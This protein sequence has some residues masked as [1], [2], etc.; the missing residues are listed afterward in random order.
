MQQLLVRHKSVPHK[1]MFAQPIPMIGH[2]DG[3]GIFGVGPVFQQRQQLT[4]VGI[5]VRHFGVVQVAKHLRFQF[6]QRFGQGRGP[7]I[8]LPIPAAHD[9]AGLFAAQQVRRHLVDEL[10]RGRK[11]QM[12]FHQVEEEEQRPFRLRLFALL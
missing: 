4:Q 11:G 12:G 3:E 6:A 5:L 1:A 2:N 9:G 10:G 8:R 7:A